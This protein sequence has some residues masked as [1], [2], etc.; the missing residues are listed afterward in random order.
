MHAWQADTEERPTLGASCDLAAEARIKDRNKKSLDRHVK[1]LTALRNQDDADKAK[2][3]MWGL[4]TQDELELARSPVKWQPSKREA[5]ALSLH[6]ETMKHSRELEHQAKHSAGFELPGAEQILRAR[7]QKM[8]RDVA[9]AAA[10]TKAA[11]Q[12]LSDAKTVVRAKWAKELVQRE[13][14]YRDHRIQSEKELAQ[15]PLMM[16]RQTRRKDGASS[17]S[18]RDKRSSSGGGSGGIQGLTDEGLLEHRAKVREM[19]QQ[20]AERKKEMLEN[21]ASRP[22]VTE[23]V[24]ELRMALMPGPHGP[25]WVPRAQMM[26]ELT[27][28]WNAPFVCPTHHTKT[29]AQEAMQKSRLQGI[30]DGAERLRVM[31]A[32]KKRARDQADKDRRDTMVKHSIAYKQSLLDYENNELQKRPLLM[33]THPT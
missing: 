18:Y 17:E 26:Q 6:L 20:Y 33:D 30:A 13:T 25:E 1:S 12:H 27:K 29:P 28:K 11:I 16:E 7:Q 21:L 4:R 19:A 10:R 5:A 2:R 23:Q 31:A 8:A 32:E 15:K 9:D 24:G 22:A 14:S 3:N